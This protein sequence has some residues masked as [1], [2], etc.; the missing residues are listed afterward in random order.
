MIRMVTKIDDIEKAIKRMA[1]IYEE[2]VIEEFIEWAKKDDEYLRANN[3]FNDQTGNLRSS[4]GAAVYKDAQLMFMTP[5]ATVLNGSRGSA[6]GRKAVESLAERTRGRIVKVMVAGMN[7]AQY[8]E[9]ID[10]KDVLESRRIQCE[11]EAHDVM[12]RAMQKAQKR[13]KEL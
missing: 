1:Q 12:E 4:L 3:G 7:Y 6:E 2:C 13:I 10:S 5:F 9:D 11:K 8:V